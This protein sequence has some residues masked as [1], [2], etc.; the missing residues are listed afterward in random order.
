MAFF[1]SC[2]FFIVYVFNL[3]SFLIYLSNRNSK[4][5]TLLFGLPFCSTYS[6]QLLLV[7]NDFYSKHVIKLIADQKRK[8]NRSKRNFSI[9]IKGSRRRRSCLT[10]CIALY[11]HNTNSICISFFVSRV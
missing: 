2:V 10:T 11:L 6:T 1:A 9:I 5:S 3:H 4:C 8:R 7:F